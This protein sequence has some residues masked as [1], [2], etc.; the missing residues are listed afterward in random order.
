MQVKSLTRLCHSYED[1]RRLHHHTV[2]E[3]GDGSSPARPTWISTVSPTVSSILTEA[4]K[5]SSRGYKVAIITDI[6]PFRAEETP[7]QQALGK[8]TT[9]PFLVS[10]SAFPL[11]RNEIVITPG[12]TITDA[13]INCHGDR[14]VVGVIQ[15][16][17]FI[18]N[19]EVTIYPN[20]V[21]SDEEVCDEDE[22]RLHMYMRASLQL[23]KMSGYTAVIL[24]DIGAT[25]RKFPAT[26][27][28]Q[29]WQEE[30]GEFCS[31]SSKGGGCDEEMVFVTMNG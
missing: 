14:P 3:R 7:F 6:D 2:A 31:T 9:L 10:E 12:V 11:A 21:S 16:P 24:T 28:R 20:G 15:C 17:M 22:H 26:M 5:L 8:A 19:R 4:S 1:A 25:M 29:G 18:L 23:A 13:R 30:V 27:I